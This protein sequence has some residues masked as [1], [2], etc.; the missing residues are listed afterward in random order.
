MKAEE[1]RIGNHISIDGVL[2]IVKEVRTNG[3]KVDI[4][5]T[6]E[7][8]LYIDLF[9]FEPILITEKGLLKLGWEYL[10]G[11]T[12]GIITKNANCKLDIDFVDG[13]LV[14]KSHY[15]GENLYRDLRIKYIHSLQNL[16][17]GLGEEL[18]SR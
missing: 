3:V 8:L 9:Q 4:P 17:F 1:L 11:R 2:C 18:I 15:E 16:F 13:E 6:G 7:E 10:N 12:S 5:E 14:V